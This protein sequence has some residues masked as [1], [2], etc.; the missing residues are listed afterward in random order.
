[1]PIN[2]PVIFYHMKSYCLALYN[3]ILM[4]YLKRYNI[5]SL[6]KQL[7]NYPLVLVGSSLVRIDG[8]WTHY[9]KSIP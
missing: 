8:Q 6:L 3:M 9:R 1:M 2:R 7:Y 4:F 5:K